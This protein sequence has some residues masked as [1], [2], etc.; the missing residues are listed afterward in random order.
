[1]TI[2]K[3]VKVFLQAK[4]HT[5]LPEVLLTVRDLSKSF[6]TFLIARFWTRT[7]A[8]FSP[9]VKN[10]LMNSILDGTNKLREFFPRDFSRSDFEKHKPYILSMV[11][12]PR[13]KLHHFKKGGLLFNGTD[14]SGTIVKMLTDEVFAVQAEM[15]FSTDSRFANNMAG[16]K[17]RS[18]EYVRE[19]LAQKP[20]EQSLDPLAY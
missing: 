15:C 18:E 20:R 3:K 12:D 7:G 5:T 19:Y 4:L 16:F 2:C 17:R 11:L 10:A 1:M 9:T 14:F 13:V 6:E 8:V